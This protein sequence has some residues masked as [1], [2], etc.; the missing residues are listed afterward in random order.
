MPP[1]GTK[2]PA[3]TPARIRSNRSGWCCCIQAYCCAEEQANR[4]SSC[5]SARARTFANVRAHLRMVSRTGHSQAESMCAWP[6]AETSGA[7]ALAGAES[8]PASRPRA[9]PAPPAMSFTSSR[10]AI[11][12]SAVS[13]RARRGSPSSIEVTVPSS[14][15]TS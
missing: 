14:T 5:S 4:R 12:W 8:T 2:W 7:L 15:S 9:A 11:S 3:A 1:T 6:A 13:T 10:S